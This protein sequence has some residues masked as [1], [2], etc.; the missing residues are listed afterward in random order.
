MPI[1][2]SS[3]RDELFPGLR[4][5]EGKYEQI[6]TQYDKVFELGKSE[7]AL[8]RT[9]QMAY[10]PLAVQKNEGAATYFDNAAGQRFTWNL[11]HTAF[12]LGYAITREAI[13]D[14]LYKAQF[15]PSNLG[16]VESFGQTKEIIHA[17][18]L[19]TA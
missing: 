9:T 7:M 14:N 6:P 12:G 5:V 17:N 3:I 4:G 18:V 13:D 10:L 1:S 11:Q 8:E 16:L 19:N 15:D 2:L